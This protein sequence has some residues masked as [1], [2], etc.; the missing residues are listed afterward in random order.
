MYA[1]SNKLDLTKD[2][3]Y[4]HPTSKQCNY[5]VNLSPYM[6]KSVLPIGIIVMWN[7]YP[8]TVPSG[9]SLCDGSNN[10]PD[11][12]DRFIIGAGNSYGTGTTGGEDKVILTTGQMP[13]HTHDTSA[14]DTSTLYVN[15]RIVNDGAAVTATSQVVN[16]LRL[17]PPHGMSWTGYTLDIGGAMSVSSVGSSQPHNNMPPYY[18]LCF[19]MKTSD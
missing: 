17:G 4:K 3:V 6:L 10:T 16:Y 9:W 5:Y 13:S 11:L 7:G 19:I 2:T 15:T 18:A 12:R 8:N 1:G 14:S